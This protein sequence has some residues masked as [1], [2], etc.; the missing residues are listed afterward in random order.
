MGKIY[1]MKGL[2]TAS[3]AQYICSEKIK[4]LPSLIC[5]KVVVL[6]GSKGQPTLHCVNS[7]SHLLCDYSL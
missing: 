6:K 3:H 4:A 5:G 2:Q 7:A 1:I